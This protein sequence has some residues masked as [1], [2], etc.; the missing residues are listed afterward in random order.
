VLLCQV[1][2]ESYSNSGPYSMRTAV[3]AA[4]I[5]LLSVFVEKLA[6]VSSCLVSGDA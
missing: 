3:K 1:L 2:V 5:Q 6:D 4:F